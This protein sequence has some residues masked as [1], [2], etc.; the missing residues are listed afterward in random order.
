MEFKVGK[1]K[2]IA[3]QTRRTLNCFR[4]IQT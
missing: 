1:K 4:R 3:Y 2:T